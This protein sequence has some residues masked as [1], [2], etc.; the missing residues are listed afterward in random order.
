M[1]RALGRGFANVRRHHQP[2]AAAGAVA[3][4]GASVLG[5]ASACINSLAAC[6]ALKQR[7]SGHCWEPRLHTVQLAGKW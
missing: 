1:W 4:S 7:P 2:E 3:G 5:V 6:V